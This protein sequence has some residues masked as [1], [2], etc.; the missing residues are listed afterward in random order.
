MKPAIEPVI[1]IRPS[2]AVAHVAADLLDEIER[3]GDV[4]VDDCAHVVEVLVEEAVA[5][6]AAGIGQQR[7]DR[8][9]AS[10]A[11]QS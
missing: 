3:A 9:A 1:R 2:P 5:E 11:A 7:I 4:G 10:S 6:P 8:P